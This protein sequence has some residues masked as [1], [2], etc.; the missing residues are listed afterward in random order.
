M[1]VFAFLQQVKYKENYMKQLGI[2][3][4]I[5][6]RPEHFHHRAVTDAVSDVS[7]QIFHFHMHTHVS[8]GVTESDTALNVCLHPTSL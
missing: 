5:P 7:A 8:M 6:D 1:A 4:S 2:W 3:R